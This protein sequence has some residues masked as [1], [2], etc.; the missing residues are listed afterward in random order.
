MKNGPTSPAKVLTDRFV[1][2]VKPPPSGRQEYRDATLPGFALRVRA[3][4]ARS[5]TIRY[6]D[7][8]DGKQ[9]RASWPYPEF[10]LAEARE[11]AREARRKV[12]DGVSPVS[13]RVAARAAREARKATSLPETVGAL[14]DEYIERYLEKKVRRWKAAKGEINNHIRPLV[15][16][17]RLDEISKAHVRE[18]LADIEPQ[19]PVAANR[20]LQRLRAVFNWAIEQDLVINNPTAGIKKP[21]KEKPRSRVLSDDELV[22]VWRAC[23]DLS[24]PARPYMQFLILTGQRPDDVRSMPW[25]ELDLDMRNWV[26]SADRYKGTRDH[27]VPL[28]NDHFKLLEQL[29]FR[30][31]GGYVFSASAGELPYGNLVRPKQALDK[32]SEVTNWTLHDIRRT[33]RTGLSRLGIRPDIAERVIG[34]SVGGRLGE[35]YDIYSYRAEKLAALEAWGAHLQKIVEGREADN[36][37]E[38]REAGK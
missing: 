23:D 24:H 7:P 20:A 10:K 25:D 18:M 29:P 16:D 22:A 3:D 14:C 33:V 30:E 37:V 26:I 35:T 6:R 28:T 17:I 19:Y 21:T 34:H 12:S 31:R 13:A 27:L 11:E 36:V 4:G 32:A 5:F 8:H 1:Q 15:G 38:F 2:T 9:K